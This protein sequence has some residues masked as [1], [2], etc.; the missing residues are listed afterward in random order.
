MLARARD[1][2]TADERATLHPTRTTHESKYIN[3]V[4]IKRYL[5]GNCGNYDGAIIEDHSD[6]E[7]SVRE[8]IILRKHGYI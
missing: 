1:I 8:P 2:L 7:R 6:D 5:I 4:A 3:S